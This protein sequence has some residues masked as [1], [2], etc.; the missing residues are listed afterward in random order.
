[1]RVLAETIYRSLYVPASGVLLKELTTYP[2]SGRV[3]RQ[4]A[5]AAPASSAVV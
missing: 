4:L 2:R 1:M 3:S 5:A